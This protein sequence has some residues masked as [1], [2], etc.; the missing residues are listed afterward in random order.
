MLRPVLPR[1][2]ATV[3][4]ALVVAAL[5]ANQSWLDAHFLPSFFVPRHWYVALESTVRIAI[6]AGGIVLLLGRV[7]I[8]R[9][10]TRA[11]ALTLQVFLAV[12]LAVVA[13]EFAARAMHQQPAEWHLRGEEPRRQEDSRLGWVLVP[14]RSGR[15][16][17]SGR[18]LDYST[19]IAGY[20]VR[21]VDAAVD[22]E[23]PTVIFV[24]ESVMFGEGLTWQES[25]PAQVEML[26]GI[27]SANLAVHGYSTDQMYLRLQRELPRFRR[28]IAVV[29]IFMTELFGRN[30]DADRPHLGPGL[31]WLP[32]V[33][34]PRLI[35]MA[36]WLVP[37]RRVA[38]VDRGV[39]VTRQTLHALVR[40][41]RDRGATPLVVVPVFGSEDRSQQALRERI[42][43]PDLPS[44]RVPLDPDW[45]LSWDRHPNARAANVIAA[46]IAS[47]LHATPPRA[48]N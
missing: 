17:I 19:D 5:L 12:V 2:F 30:L 27:Q 45:R 34:K 16:S 22:R 18:S 40:L 32:A 42:M 7:R 23:Q 1:I 43:T 35:A 10:L 8:A 26:S 15:I 6:A 4:L 41:A 46:A 38:T 47:R 33:R 37:F 21:Q 20:R 36:E 25:I 48:T 39:E 28:P 44:L 9:L 11:P 31:V 3:G 24:G 13:G 29:G 14:A